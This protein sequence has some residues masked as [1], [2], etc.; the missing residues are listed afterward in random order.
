MQIFVSEYFTSGACCNDEFSSSLLQEGV[1]MLQAVLED[2]ASLPNVEIITTLDHRVASQFDF[3]CMNSLV[4]SHLVQTSLE[5]KELFQKLARNADAL[6]VIAP[7]TDNALANRKEIADILDVKWIGCSTDA[8]QLCT[9]KLALATHFEKQDIP[10]IPTFPL[11]WEDDLQHSFPIVIKPRDGAGSQMMFLVQNSLDWIAA[12][13]AYAN[14][15][16]NI[17]AIWQPYIVGT[18]VSIAILPEEHHVLPVTL[19][20]FSEENLFQYEGGTTPFFVDYHETLISLVQKAT[21]TI[22]GLNG[23]VG[24]DLILPENEPHKPLI[25][26]I[27]PRLTTSYVGYR[28]LTDDNLMKRILLPQPIIPEQQSNLICWKGQTVQFDSDG[29]VTPMCPQ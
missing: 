12:K 5:E 22:P 19:Q 18:S 29:T 7:E 4:K 27:N 1:A 21:A 6:F 23:Y 20:R 2:C 10:T 24:F 8:V 25:V 15:K 28:A 9:D 3:S 14:S 16:E 26:E 17:K 13:K 11:N